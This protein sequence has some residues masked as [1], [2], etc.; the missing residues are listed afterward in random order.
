MRSTEYKCARCDLYV[1]SSRVVNDGEHYFCRECWDEIGAKLKSNRCPVCGRDL[2]PWDIKIHDGVDYCEKCYVKVSNAS[3][4]FMRGVMEKAGLLEPREPEKS[5][6]GDT[7]FAE[8]AGLFKCL[9]DPC[10]IKIIELL[11]KK[12]LCVFEFIEITGFQYSAISYHLKMLKELG[13]IYSFRRGNFQVYLL[14]NKGEVVF[15]II[16]TTRALI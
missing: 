8:I 15:E 1:P 2:T 9:S 6:A 13:L 16:K 3:D 10:R 7:E 12:E 14:T 5:H 11:G 4:N